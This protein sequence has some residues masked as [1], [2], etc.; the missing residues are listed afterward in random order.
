MLERILRS[1]MQSK[2]LK[3]KWKFIIARILEEAALNG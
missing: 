3:N 1:G 2:F